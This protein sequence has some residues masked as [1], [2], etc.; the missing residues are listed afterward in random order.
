[1]FHLW[2]IN[3]AIL[4]IAVPI[5][6]TLKAILAGLI[7]ILYGGMFFYFSNH[8]GYVNAPPDHPKPFGAE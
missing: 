1:M 6:V 2:Y 5:R 7:I 4:L 8:N 3:L